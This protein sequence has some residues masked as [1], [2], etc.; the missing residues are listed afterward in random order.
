MLYKNH[1]IWL[2]VGKS[3]P[4]LVFRLV[5]IIEYLFVYAL[6]L[7]SCVK[8]Q[9]CAVCKWIPAT[10]AN[11]VVCCTQQSTTNK[12]PGGC[13]QRGR[14]VWAWPTLV[15]VVRRTVIVWYRSLEDR[16]WDDWTLD[17]RQAT[18][19]NSTP[20]TQTCS[21]SSSIFNIIIILTEYIHTDR[22]LY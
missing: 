6:S 10:N 13:G 8:W 17:A 1:R 20:S 9:P 21:S 12:Q 11:S 19:T 2:P 14:G 7:L 22:E 3:R 16:R 4:L 18:T 5:F 15:S